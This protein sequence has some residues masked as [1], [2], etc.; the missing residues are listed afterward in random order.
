[1]IDSYGDL[2]QDGNAVMNAKNSVRRKQEPAIAADAFAVERGFA[3][4]ADFFDRLHAPPFTISQSVS[5]ARALRPH[6]ERECWRRQVQGG[7]SKRCQLGVS[8]GLKVREFVA[9]CT[10]LAPRTLA[11]AEAVIEAAEC[12]PRSSSLRAFVGPGDGHDASRRSGV[13]FFQRI[14]ERFADQG[15]LAAGGETE[16]SSEKSSSPS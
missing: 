3:A 15:S 1:M 8:L 13:S 5:I 10:G 7:L 11:Q 12:N 6:V 9:C 14:P 4:I 16:R 2:Y